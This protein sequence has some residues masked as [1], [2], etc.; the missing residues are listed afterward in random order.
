[1]LSLLLFVALQSW[2]EADDIPKITIFAPTQ[3]IKNAS[4]VFPVLLRIPQSLIAK[5]VDQ[6]FQH[7]APV[8]QEVLG[9]KSTGTAHCEG[10]VTCT[11]EEMVDGA[12]FSCRISGTVQSDTC[13]TNGPATIQSHACT[14]YVAHKRFFFDG[15]RFSSFPTTLAART[16]LTITSSRD[17]SLTAFGT[18]ER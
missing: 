14:T 2:I 16:Q 17:A 18:K 7:S 6:D 5:S 15:Y 3:G 13:G 12:A 10:K 4:E 11:I 9:T 1:M 8:Q